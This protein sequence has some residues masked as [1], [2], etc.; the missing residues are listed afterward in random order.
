M[1]SGIPGTSLRSTNVLARTVPIDEVVE[2]D[3]FDT[4]DLVRRVGGLGWL[5]SSDCWSD[6][7]REFAI[8]GSSNVFSFPLNSTPKPSELLNERV[9]VCISCCIA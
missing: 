3:L 7:R 9:R 2:L 8:A 5:F 4:F 1:H 6:S